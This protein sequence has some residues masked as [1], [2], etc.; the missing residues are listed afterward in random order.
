MLESFSIGNWGWISF[1]LVLTAVFSKRLLIWFLG[2]RKKS[3]LLLNS[4]FGFYIL[5]VPIKDIEAIE[6]ILHDRISIS[7]Q[8]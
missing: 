2:S 8:M 5:A 4:L 7:G 3:S 6:Q 1:Y